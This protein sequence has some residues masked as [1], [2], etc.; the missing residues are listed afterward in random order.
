MISC[1]VVSERVLHGFAHVI[2]H[3]YHQLEDRQLK[4]LVINLQLV[5]KDGCTYPISLT[6]LTKVH[7]PSRAAVLSFVLPQVT[8]L[9][10]FPANG[11]PRDGAGC[12]CW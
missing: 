7:T 4:R 2:M 11:A 9:S 1:C 6:V 3:F 5:Q 12:Y 8:C 10:T